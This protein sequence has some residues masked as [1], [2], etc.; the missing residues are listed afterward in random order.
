MLTHS[1]VSLSLQVFVFDGSTGATVP[2]EVIPHNLTQNFTI[3]LWLKHEHHP[4]QDKHAKEHILCN[5]DDHRTFKMMRSFSRW[6]FF[7]SSS[8]FVFPTEMNRHHFALFVRNCRLILLLRR[9]FG[10]GD[11]KSFRP[12][13]FR[14]KL[15]Q[16]TT[17][18]EKTKETTRVLLTSFARGCSLTAGP[19]LRWPVASL[20]RLHGVPQRP[21]VRGW[22]SPRGH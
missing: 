2:A 6:D 5:A 4:N 11:L 18:D 7:R 17:Y 16:V 13:E 1:F 15:P 12:A 3:S 14:W 8:T 20:C 10:D 9:E 19:G 22:P 21:A